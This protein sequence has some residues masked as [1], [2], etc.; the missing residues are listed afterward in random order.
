[1]GLFVVHDVV[2]TRQALH[3]V[4]ERV[5]RGD[6]VGLLCQLGA[7]PHDGVGV[8][9]QLT[10]VDAVALQ[11]TDLLDGHR[12]RA[13]PVAGLRRHSQRGHGTALAPTVTD[14]QLNADERGVG[15]RIPLVDAELEHAED[16]AQH[17]E[18]PE[19]AHFGHGLDGHLAEDAAHEVVQQGVPEDAHL[20]RLLARLQRA[21]PIPVLHRGAHRV[22]LLHQQLLCC[23][24]LRAGSAVT[25]ASDRAWR[26]REKGR[27]VARTSCLVLLGLGSSQTCWDHARG[28]LA[29]G[30]LDQLLELCSAPVQVAYHVQGGVAWEVPLLPECQQLVPGPLVHLLHP[31]NRE[32]ASQMIL[33]VQVLQ[34][35]A[36]HPVLNRVHH[37]CLCL[38]GLALL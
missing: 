8:A 21:D 32:P 19:V 15:L 1:M 7:V 9:L 4:V 25:I 30:L 33:V 14:V 17:E 16:D 34:Q 11:A 13:L 5:Q 18:L 27:G 22:A 36:I 29:V 23:K 20:R 2:A 38:D 6:F 12:Q 37:L 24:L 10:L 28:A 26:R 35:L 3:H 31:A